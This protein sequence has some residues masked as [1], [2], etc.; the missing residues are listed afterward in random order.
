MLW[1]LFKKKLPY[2]VVVILLFTAFYIIC[3]TLNITCLFYEFAKVPCPTCYMG[4]AIMSLLKC[5]FEKYIAYNVM[6]APV[7]V[8]FLLELF[9]AYFS[10]H[11][12]LI[13]AYSISV[14]AINTLYYLV[15][16]NF[17]S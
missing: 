17:F 6:A 14:L 3:R 16:F 12:N 9:G 5:D 1:R 8:A 2:E 10:K 11:K 15:R 4:R 7:A 13:H